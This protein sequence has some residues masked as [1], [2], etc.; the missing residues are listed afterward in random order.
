VQTPYILDL[1]AGLTQVLNDGTTAYVYGLDLV[2][3]QTGIYEEYPLRDALGSVR[4]MTDQS[5][6]ITGYKSFEPYGS[7]L[8]SSGETDTPYGFAGEWT[9]NSGMQYLRVRYYGP[10]MGRFISRD[11]W[12]G[13]YAYPSSLNRWM[14]VNGNPINVT[15]PSG[16][17]YPDFNGDGKCDGEDI[18][19]P[20]V[21]GGG[22]MLYAY[23]TRAQIESDFVTGVVSESLRNVSWFIPPAQ[24]ALESSICYENGYMMAGRLTVDVLSLIG[25]G[26]GVGGGTALTGGGVVSCGVGVL[27]VSYTHLTL[28]TIYS[29]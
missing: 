18:K 21:I 14:Y 24:K 5:S 26:I 7:V 6:A 2:S 25:G 3:Q 8:A 12:E 4:Q 15:D 20:L 23:Y 19:I 13:V 17:C 10:D 29:V 1:N 28:P 11:R 22:Q 27:S 16:M 9:D